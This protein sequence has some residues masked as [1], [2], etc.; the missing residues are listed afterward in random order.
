MFSR[1]WFIYVFGRWIF[2]SGIAGSLV[3]YIFADKFK[4]PTI[5]AFL[6]NQLCLACVFWYVDK[7][8]FQRHF[9][10]VK[11]IFKFPRIKGQFDYK[12]QID[13]I[14]QEFG[15]LVQSFNASPEDP[16]PWLNNLLDLEHAVEMTERVLSE[17][18]VSVDSERYNIIRDNEKR[19]L[20]NETH[21][22]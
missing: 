11:Q 7:Y 16:Q 18:G 20:Y 13:K 3:Q 21:K 22:E 15:E 2:L 5:P 10:K 8:I 14:Q 9:N 12:H 17:K 1:E 6:L 4:I 19:G